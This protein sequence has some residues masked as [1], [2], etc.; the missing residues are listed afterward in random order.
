[1]TLR[2]AILGFVGV[3]ALCGF[4]Y[5]ND[6]ILNQTYLVGNNLPVAVYGPLI[7]FVVAVNPLLARLGRRAALSGRELAVILT[8]VLA[9]CCIPASGLLRTF[10]NSLILPHHYNRLNPGWR[11]KE[12]L[13]LAPKYMLA[14][15]G[16][17]EDTVLNGFVQGLGEPNRHIALADVPWHAWTGALAFWLPI[18]LTL[19]FG[20]TALSLVLHRQWADHE[21]L[22]YP[23]AEFADSL[24]PEDGGHGS[25]LLRN[26]LFW[27]GTG[28]VFA[29]HFNNFLATFFPEAM[30][31][32]TRQLNLAGMAD[33]VPYLRTGGGTRLLAPVLY[34]TVIGV[35][36]FVPKDVSFSIGIG[37]FLWAMAVGFFATYGI[38]LTS[39]AGVSATGYLSLKPQT[40]ALLG[41]NLGVFGVVLFCGRNYYLAVA[42]RAVFAGGPTRVEA[43]AVWGA[44]IAALCLLAFV[45]QLSATGL[46]WQ[47]ALFYT[48]VLVV[49]YVVMGRVFA[50]TGLF[51][52][53]PFFFPCVTIW[54]L[55]G[56]Q[57]LGPR[58]MLILFLL[59]TVLLVDPRES[60]MPFVVN[61][62]KLLELRRVPLGRS[63]ILFG[64]ALVLGLL[65]AL[66]L[67]LYFQYDLGYA[68]WDTWAGDFVP[69]MAFDNAV[70]AVELLEAQGSLERAADL[71][72]WGRFRAVAPNGL[73]VAALVAGLALALACY[74][75][76][77]RT[78]WWPL[79]PVLFLTWA[80]EPPWR[81]SGSFLIGWAVKSAVIN[82]GGSRLYQRLK[83]LLLGLIAGEIFGAVVPTIVG[84]GYYLATGNPPKRFWVLP[85]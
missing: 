37:P 77:L 68:K 48:A 23:I 15:V 35:A 19:W 7:L 30:I 59:T 8:L 63:A 56:A 62:L 14:D 26:R 34:A 45:L 24:L 51:Y 6:N 82:Y 31:P 50:E 42:R 55:M 81:L 44:R 67:T 53:Q 49:F 27:I 47:L 4:N 73:C 2:A 46:G 12:V 58:T 16:V 61:S 84:A 74:T 83:P 76:R 72:G 10:T 38:S 11:D 18:V 1:M 36:Y 79:H 64:A 75:G 60:L 29:V 20:L 69:K 78:T 25:S 54:G 80:T 33:L 57:A 40:F 85:L 43:G 3:I 21:L 66:P 65:V 9:C 13:A 28:F 22:P 5:V 70:S 41:A 71:R 17:D 52:N 39:S 32:I